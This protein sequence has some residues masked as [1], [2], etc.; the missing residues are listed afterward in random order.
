MKLQSKQIPIAPI[1]IDA[2]TDEQIEIMHAGRLEA[3]K[4]MQSL[5]FAIGH[6]LSKKRKEVAEGKWTEYC[7]SI[8]M[9]TVA[10]Y[11]YIDRFNCR[12]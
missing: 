7:K 8:G 1:N 6:A 2:I 10:A 5:Q 11:Q 4:S 9:S 3:A 12:S